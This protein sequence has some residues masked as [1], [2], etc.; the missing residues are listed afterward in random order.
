MPMFG[1]KSS[2]LIA[3]V[4]C[5]GAIA[6]VMAVATPASAHTGVGRGEG[7]LSAAIGTANASG[8]GEL[9]LAPGCVYALSAP[10]PEITS[11]VVVHARHGT[12]TRSS[13]TAFG[14][15]AVGRVGGPTLTDATLTNGDAPLFGGGIANRGRLTVT[16]SAIVGIHSQYAGGIGALSSATTRIVRTSIMRNTAE[17]IDG[18]AA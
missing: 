7:G 10:L 9:M 17:N 11:T 12:I 1:R 5:V 4:T 18:G 3:Q 14:I 13:T 8:G 15:L 2:A 6:T 16:D